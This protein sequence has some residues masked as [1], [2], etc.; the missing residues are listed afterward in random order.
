MAQDATVNNTVKSY[1]AASSS[2][3]N[4]I[5]GKDKFKNRGGRKGLYL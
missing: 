4:L 1:K 5:C 2:V 3:E